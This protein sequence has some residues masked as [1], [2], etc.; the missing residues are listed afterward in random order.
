VASSGDIVSELDVIL[1][2][3]Q[4]AT[5]LAQVGRNA[6]NAFAHAYIETLR[7]RSFTRLT[8]DSG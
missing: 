7:A 8:P 2:D 3:R 5:D 6:V 1:R 4:A